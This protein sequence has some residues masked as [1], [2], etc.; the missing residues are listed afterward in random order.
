[1]DNSSAHNVNTY[2]D[3]NWGIQHLITKNNV[4]LSLVALTVYHPLKAKWK[5]IRAYSIRD[6]QVCNFK[7]EQNLNLKIYFRSRKCIFVLLFLLY[8]RH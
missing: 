2:L 6:T 5:N 8:L 4:L 3:Y 7:L 1:M